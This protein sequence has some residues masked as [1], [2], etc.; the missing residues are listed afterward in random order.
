[1]RG[2]NSLRALYLFLEGEKFESDANIKEEKFEK[3][4]AHLRQAAAYL[5]SEADMVES[6]YNEKKVKK[7]K[8]YE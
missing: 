7:L 5:R 6:E 3:S 2:F 1:M 8:K 4:Y